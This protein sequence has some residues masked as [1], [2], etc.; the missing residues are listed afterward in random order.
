[1]RFSLK[2]DSMCYND[3]FLMA[4]RAINLY[5]LKAKH[6]YKARKWEYF[7]IPGYN[8]YDRTIIDYYTITRMNKD[9]CTQLV[10]IYWL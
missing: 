5:E 8:S 7:A 4:T 2:N 6:G 10:G 9:G 3:A 1:M